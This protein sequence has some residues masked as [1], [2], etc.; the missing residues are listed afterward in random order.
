MEGKAGGNLKAINREI[1]GHIIRLRNNRN[2]AKVE[3]L[4]NY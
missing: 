3:Y 1:N 4:Y 2:K